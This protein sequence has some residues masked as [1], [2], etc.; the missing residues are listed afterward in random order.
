VPDPALRARNLE[1]MR[2][3]PRYVWT[4]S[5]L[6]LVRIPA[7]TFTMGGD[8]AFFDRELPVRRVTISRPLYVAA[9]LT[10][11]QL[12]RR[13]RP[14]L[15]PTPKDPLADE[16]PIGRTSFADAQAFCA[17]L[18]EIDGL[19]YR[20]PTE[21]EWEYASRGGL[22]SAPYPWGHEPADSSRCNYL[23]SGGVPVASYPPNAFGLFDTV[24]NFLEWT[25]D[26][27]REDTYSLT[28]HEVS[29]PLVTEGETGNRVT[30][31]GPAGLPFCRFMCRNAFRMRTPEAKG[32]G[33]RVVAPAD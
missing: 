5:G 16:L 25:M 2:R 23:H 33:F 3:D 17:M 26:V 19:A 24:G 1:Q 32:F 9:W 6:P 7:G 30:R 13:L 14:E 20:L 28:P 31:G 10:T 11:R 27:Y 21:A 18:S 8:P 12:W 22:E 15:V 4:R 29:D